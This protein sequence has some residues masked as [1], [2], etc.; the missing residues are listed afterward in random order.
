[1]DAESGSAKH[2][3]AYYEKI[4]RN[5]DRLRKFADNHETPFY[6]FDAGE[7]RHNIKRFRD[8]FISEG[9]DISVFYAVKSNSYGSLLKTVVDE[10][11][12]L[13]VSSHRE[14]SLA[15]KA[16]AKRIIYTGPAKSQ[17]DFEQILDHHDV[18]TVN[19]ESVREMKLL[20]DMAAKR[21]VTMRCGVRVFTSNQAGWTK[22]GIPLIKLADFMR[23]AQKLPSLDFCG[24]HFH[25]SFVVESDKYVNT[26]EELSRYLLEKLTEEERKKLEYLDIGG[27]FYPEPFQ[28]LY[29]WNAD[30]TAN[31]PGDYIDRILEDQ[32]PCR[33]IP[34]KT[35]PIEKFAREIGKAFK[36]LIQPVLPNVRLYA[37]PGR[38]ISHSSMHFVLKLMDVKG[39]SMGI[40]DGGNNM[41]GWELF[42]FFYYV[43][44][45]NLSQFDSKREI[46]F[47]TYGSLCTPNDI[48][49]YYMHTAGAPREG[50]ILIIPFQGAYTHAFAQNFIKEIPPVYDEPLK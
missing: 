38:F 7:V 20:A 27:G 49:S 16:G 30:Q 24:I 32:S 48:W 4:R 31:L 1:M 46:P 26:M 41:V 25:I 11:V 15:L 37:E 40:A 21:G 33:T 13:D 36:I 9:T 34:F 12:H 8:A 50:D 10:G 39:D 44:M 42:E 45:F 6:I 28:A 3:E 29:T 2:F 47:I 5:S 18:I 19:L 43:P 22:F 14:L 17:K 23:Q 35:E